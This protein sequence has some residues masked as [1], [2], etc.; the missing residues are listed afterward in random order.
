MQLQRR[1]A[2]CGIVRDKEG[3]KMN[4]DT[5]C[6]TCCRNK[7]E[8]LLEQYRVSE[9]TRDILLKRIDKFLE[10]DKRIGDMPA[11]VMMAEILSIVDE[12]VGIMDAYEK[13]KKKYNR[14][15]LGLEEAVIA[16]IEKAEDEFLAAIQYAVTGNY[17]DFGAMDEVS[18]DLLG[19]LL[20]NRADVELDADELAR[21]KNELEEAETLV[22]ITDNAGEIVLDKVFIRIL[23]KLYPQLDITVVVRGFPTLNDATYE[24]AE[25]I[26]LTDLVNVMPNGTDVPGTPIDEINPEVRYL[27]DEADLCI[28]KGQGNFETLHGSGRN[29]F[30]LFLCKCE[31][32]TS[33][34]QTK[35]FTPVLN[36]ELRIVQS[37]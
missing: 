2:E 5:V 9:E 29:V 13:P 33:K 31:L 22:Y 25:D 8:G 21:L 18:E 1:T 11:P 17:I 6:L 27:I 12:K 3:E 32:F 15:L 30:Y 37:I 19:E 16:D 36:N 14:K 23:K 28:A 4:A 34:F 35:R 10:K 26:G 7:A 24:D 20:E